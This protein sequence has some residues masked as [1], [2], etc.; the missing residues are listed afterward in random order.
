M[1]HEEFFQLVLKER[2]YQRQR[3]GDDHGVTLAQWGQ[4]IC[5]YAT[6]PSLPECFDTAGRYTFRNCM[7]KVAAIALAAWEATAE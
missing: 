3:W 5:N 2:E 1:P 7:V 4:F 6:R